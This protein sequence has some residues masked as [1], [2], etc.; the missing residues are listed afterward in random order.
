MRPVAPQFY[1]LE[2]ARITAFQTDEEESFLRA[3]SQKLENN[4]LETLQANN[5]RYGGRLM[6]VASPAFENLDAV[7]V[8]TMSK[9]RRMRALCQRQASAR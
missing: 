5:Y 6:P 8:D 1:R 7:S 3:V 2:K 4:S 9:H